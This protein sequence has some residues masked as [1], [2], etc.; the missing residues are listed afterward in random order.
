[1]DDSRIEGDMMSPGKRTD[2][3]GAQRLVATPRE[4]FTF[5][6]SRHLMKQELSLEIGSPVSA[7]SCTSP[8]C[9]FSELRG[10]ESG[11]CP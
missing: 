1:M 4:T 3:A 6:D 2:G 7:R 8:L 10:H 9:R 5:P 11:K